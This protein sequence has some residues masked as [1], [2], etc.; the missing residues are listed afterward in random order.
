MRSPYLILPVIASRQIVLR[1]NERST[2]L[3]LVDATLG[4]HDFS[5]FLGTHPFYAFGLTIE[6]IFICTSS[7]ILINLLI[8]KMANTYSRYDVKADKIL[9]LLMTSNTKA[10]LLVGEKSPLCILPAPLNL[11]TILLYPVHYICV[12]SAFYGVM[13]RSL[14]GFDVSQVEKP[15]PKSKRAEEARRK[16]IRA[17]SIAG[18]VSDWLLGVPFVFLIAAMECWTSLSPSFSLNFLRKLAVATISAPYLYV[19]NIA[20]LSRKL[21]STRVYLECYPCYPDDPFDQLLMISYDRVPRKY[22]FDENTREKLQ[23]VYTNTIR[24]NSSTLSKV[25]PLGRLQLFFSD[26]ELEILRYRRIL[27]RAMSGRFF[28]IVSGTKL[29]SLPTESVEKEFKSLPKEAGDKVYFTPSL[30]QLPLLEVVNRDLR[31]VEDGV[32]VEVVIETFETGYEEVIASHQITKQELLEWA[33]SGGFRGSL[34]LQLCGSGHAS[35]ELPVSV[36]CY[37]P[38]INESPAEDTGAATASSVDE[39]SC[40][41]ITNICCKGKGKVHITSSEPNKDNSSFSR[42]SERSETSAES[43]RSVK[44]QASESRKSIKQLSFNASSKASLASSEYNGKDLSFSWKLDSTD[45]HP[46]TSGSSHTFKR[47]FMRDYYGC[48]D[49]LVSHVLAAKQEFFESDDRKDIFEK[50]KSWVNPDTTQ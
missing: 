47:K 50:L 40:C 30:I 24:Q 37:L 32:T 35:I 49:T 1:R 18:T 36:S 25:W 29:M 39:S 5:A 41:S 21:F 31:I 26:C 10:H 16:K 7:I 17:I 38:E 3:T 43:Y 23:Q 6:I 11:V 12:N 48:S 27:I 44:R 46:P 28:A 15:H 34:E 8:A 19:T 14:L 4:S 22:E 13:A 9:K 2:F 33:R 45:H 42:A 20:Y